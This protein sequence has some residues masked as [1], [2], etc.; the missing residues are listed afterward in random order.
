MEQLEE[1]L[2]VF[3][4]QKETLLKFDSFFLFILDS[5]Q[6][7]CSD[8]CNLM[9]L[10]LNISLQQYLIIRF[11][12]QHLQQFRVN[13]EIF[14]HQPQKLLFFLDLLSISL[15][16]HLVSLDLF[17]FQRATQQPLIYQMFLIII[18]STKATHFPSSQV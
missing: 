2:K 7:F 16:S 6:D 15:K 9:I 10:Y 13:C 5:C 18:Q 11:S 14:K 3:N 17:H 1:M 8:F 12:N 4:L